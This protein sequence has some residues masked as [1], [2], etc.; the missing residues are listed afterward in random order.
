MSVD[1]IP[2]SGIPA[3]DWRRNLAWVPQ[4]P[5]LFNDTLS[6]NLRLARPNASTED[7]LRACRRA[8]MDDFISALPEGLETVLGER[9]ARLSG[10]EAQRVA[11]ARAF[12]R[13]AP[14]LLLDEPTSSLDPTLESRLHAAVRDLVTGRT[15]LVIAHRLATITQADQVI[16]LASGRVVETGTHSSLL[17]LG[18]FYASL[19]HPS[20]ITDH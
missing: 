2:L 15:V 17:R 5:Y 19:F 7:I 20:L 13:D 10:G 16:V 9:G 4:H 11:L 3:E 8:G 14:F 6:A 12:L 1:G 18:G